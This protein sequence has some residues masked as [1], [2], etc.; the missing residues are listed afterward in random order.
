MAYDDAPKLLKDFL[1][2]LD[3]VNGKSSKTIYEYYLDL[4]FFLRYIKKHKFKLNDE[5]DS[6]FLDGWTEGFNYISSGNSDGNEYIEEYIYIN[7]PENYIGS[8]WTIGF[9]EGYNDY[10]LNK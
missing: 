2:Y 6:I 5:I 1:F 4:R 10:K 7:S 8:I 3:V 9:W